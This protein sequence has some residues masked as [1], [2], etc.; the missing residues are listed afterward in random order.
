[1]AMNTAVTS[2]P[3]TF[4]TWQTQQRDLTNLLQHIGLVYKHIW[5]HEHFRL[6]HGQWKLAGGSEELLK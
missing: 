3:F 2:T 4:G 1:M 5:Y 6:C